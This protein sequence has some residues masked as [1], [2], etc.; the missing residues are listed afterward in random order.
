[1]LSASFGGALGVPTPIHDG[2]TQRRRPQGQDMLAILSRGPCSRS[3]FIRVS[4]YRRLTGS[5]HRS[6]RSLRLP[7]AHA[8]GGSQGEPILNVPDDSTQGRLSRIVKRAACRTRIRPV[9]VARPGRARAGCRGGGVLPGQPVSLLRWL[10]RRE[11][12]PYVAT[13]RNP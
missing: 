12:I 6:D 11:S 1:M 2:T 9:Q 13:D 5:I 3:F 7:C 10:H 4:R 8:A